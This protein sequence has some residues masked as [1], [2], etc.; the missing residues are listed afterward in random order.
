MWFKRPEFV[1]HYGHLLLNRKIAA[2]VARGPRVTSLSTLNCQKKT[3]LFRFFLCEH[4]DKDTEKIIRGYVSGRERQTRT[5][6][7][8]MRIEITLNYSFF[9]T[10][11][12]KNKE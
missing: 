8:S 6:N 5:R 12:R 10:K 1:T 2:R 3:I 4:E 11:N 9:D 7:A